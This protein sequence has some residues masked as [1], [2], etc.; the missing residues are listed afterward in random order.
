MKSLPLESWLKRAGLN[1]VSKMWRFSFF[2]KAPWIR[3]QGFGVDATRSEIMP[4]VLTQK[5]RELPLSG[6]KEM[7]RMAAL[8]GL[9][10]TENFK[11]CRRR[12]ELSA[13]AR[14]GDRCSSWGAEC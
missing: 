13:L 9:T 3:I 12:T 8:L 4:P 10:E 7:P 2:S 14:R 6:Q 1:H 5:A 11:L